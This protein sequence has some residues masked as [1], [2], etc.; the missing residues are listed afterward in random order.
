AVAAF[1]WGSHRA[2]GPSEPAAARAPAAPALRSTSRRVRP[3]VDLAAA[4]AAACWTRDSRGVRA[5]FSSPPWARRARAGLGSASD[6][7][8]NGAA[9]QR[10]RADASIPANRDLGSRFSTLAAP[11]MAATLPRFIAGRL[12]AAA[13]VL[14]GASLACFLTFHVLRPDM[15]AGQGSFAHQLGDF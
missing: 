9:Q 11:Q 6:A 13:A 7:A 3:P 10:Q 8:A 4:S 14:A 15:F 5:I 12:L 2:A 1:A